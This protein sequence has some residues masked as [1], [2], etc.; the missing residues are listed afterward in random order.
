VEEWELTTAIV[1]L[2]RASDDVDAI[3]WCIPLGDYVSVGLSASAT[4]TELDDATLLERAASAFA[5]CGIDYRR[6][7]PDSVEL[8]ALQHSYFA[9]DRASGA[10][11]LL[12]GPSFCQVWWMAGAGVG[13][14]LAAAQLAPKILHEPRRWGAEYDRYMQQLIPIHDTFDYFA[15]SA[16]H[17]YEPEALHHFSDRFVVTNLLRLAGSTRM[18]NSGLATLASHAM[19]WLFSQPAAIR[20]YCSVMRV[21]LRKRAA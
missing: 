17:E 2:F 16:R 18:R 12:A 5:R 6:R 9:Y 20:Q 13:T 10:N 19:E 4:E 11:W 8:K 14:A 15:Q 3:A 1:R 21:G 7:Y